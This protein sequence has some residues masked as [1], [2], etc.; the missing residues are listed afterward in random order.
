MKKNILFLGGI[1]LGCFMLASI[2]QAQKQP[3]QKVM[4]NVL[5]MT[6]QQ[7]QDVVKKAGLALVGVG[8]TPTRD[9][10]LDQKVFAQQPDAGKP[11]NT[12][13]LNCY[14]FVQVL[15]PN[16]VG[17]PL[18]K[19][20]TELRKIGITRYSV[21]ET[22]TT[23]DPRENKRVRSQSPAPGKPLGPV[24]VDC[25]RYVEPIKPDPGV[26]SAPIDQA[27][28]EAYTGKG[29]LLDQH[30]GSQSAPKLTPRKK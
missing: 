5:G 18:E 7:A 16:L 11:T 28:A 6:C 2:A 20:H 19:A 13:S 14:R 17:M 1:L 9:Q 12:A 30:P 4:P 8:T 22:V 26:S 27:K 24:V 10:R 21:Q 25:Y 15:M 3:P 23:Q 29:N